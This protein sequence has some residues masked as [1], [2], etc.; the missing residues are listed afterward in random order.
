[1]KDYWGKKRKQQIGVRTTEVACLSLLV[2]MLL[3]LETPCFAAAAAA[4]AA[5]YNN[6]KV[7][8]IPSRFKAIPTTTASEINPHNPPPQAV[9]K[10]N[11]DH[12]LG[13]NDDEIF[14]VDKRTIYTGPNPLHNR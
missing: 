13:D 10:T 14:G 7:K 8:A 2:L 11:A 6:Y 1:M 5:G 4:T 12:K 9:F 3:Q